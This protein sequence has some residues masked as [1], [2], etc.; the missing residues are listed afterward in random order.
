VY[1]S[2]H[3]AERWKK[4]G[5][6]YK[7]KALI[8]VDMIGDKN[9]DVQPDLNSNPGLRRL[10]MQTA[11]DLGYASSFPN[12]PI[13]IDDDHMPFIRLGVPSVDLI[14]FD[15]PAWHKDDD[16]IDKLSAKSLEIV[17]SVVV[18][19]ISRLERQ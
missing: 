13:T 4:D 12:E 17:G 15:Y 18:E 3:L 1:G 16:T 6:L 2:R 14:D 19:M 9:L 5:S 7:I 11:A 8:N 10:V